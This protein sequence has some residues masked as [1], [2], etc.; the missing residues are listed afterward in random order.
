MK[1]LPTLKLGHSSQGDSPAS[2]RTIDLK[3]SSAPEPDS[4]TRPVAC[5]L[6]KVY[7]WLLLFSTA[8]A[9]TFCFLYLT[10]PFIQPTQNPPPPQS[11]PAL[12]ASTNSVR[13]EAREPTSL[14][15]LS[16]RLPG[17]SKPATSPPVGKRTVPPLA[18]IPTAFEPTNLRVQ[19]IITAEAP[20]GYQ[21]K[22]DLEVPVLYQSRNLRWTSNEVAQA[23]NLLLQ[24]RDYQN[25]ARNLRLEGIELQ[26]AWSQLIEASTPTSHLRADSPTLTTNQRDIGSSPAPPTSNPLQKK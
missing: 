26:T 15:P 19:H 24:L 16:D 6:H 1:P 4:S 10:K 7:P 8:V 23:Q 20:G 5:T 17:D 11:V 21:A 13:V 22:I 14:M 12:A 2:Q 9:G 3:L 18:R 25:K